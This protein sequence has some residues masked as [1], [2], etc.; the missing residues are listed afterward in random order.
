MTDSGVKGESLYLSNSRKRS[1]QSTVKAAGSA[2]LDDARLT[3]ILI[4]SKAE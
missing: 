3:C 4:D 1:V 2:S